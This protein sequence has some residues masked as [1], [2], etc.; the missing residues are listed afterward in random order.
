MTGNIFPAHHWSNAE[1]ARS[2]KP[3]QEWSNIYHKVT[4]FVSTT[5]PTH[6]PRSSRF[7]YPRSRVCSAVSCARGAEKALLPSGPSWFP[8]RG[9]GRTQPSYASF[10]AVIARTLP[11]SPQQLASV[12][13]CGRA[14]PQVQPGPP[15]ARH[16]PEHPDPLPRRL[17]PLPEVPS[18]LRCARRGIL[19]VRAAY[20][21]CPPAWKAR[22]GEAQTPPSGS[23]ATPPDPLCL[24]PPAPYRVGAMVKDARRAVRQVLVR[25]ILGHHVAHPPPQRSRPAQGRDRFH[26]EAQVLPAGGGERNVCAETK[27]LH[28]SILGVD[29]PLPCAGQSSASIAERR[30]NRWSRGRVRTLSGGLPILAVSLHVRSRSPTPHPGRAERA[31][32][33]HCRRST[34]VIAPSSPCARR[35]PPVTHTLALACT[36]EW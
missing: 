18:S 16:L 10:P 20:Q 3:N 34:S 32:N 11:C 17:E 29:M 35:N 24:E 13:A 15:E 9:G 19:P 12:R 21:T 36:R 23:P 27:P 5:L 14:G 33:S 7:W 4:S 6:C 31:L 26:H 22:A 2:V 28:R 30:V 25:L 8:L 1:S